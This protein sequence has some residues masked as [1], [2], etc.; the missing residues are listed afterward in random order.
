MHR[1]ETVM[2]LGS[3]RAWHRGFRSSSPTPKLSGF[4]GFGREGG[5]EPWPTAS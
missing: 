1:M 5:K 3:E 4:M 2:H